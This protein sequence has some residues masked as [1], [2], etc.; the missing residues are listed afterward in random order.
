MYTNPRQMTARHG[1]CIFTL[2]VLTEELVDGFAEALRQV[3]VQEVPP[4]ESSGRAEAG[5]HG[6]QGSAVQQR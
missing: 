1:P 3:G 4:G 2:V 5:G 6:T